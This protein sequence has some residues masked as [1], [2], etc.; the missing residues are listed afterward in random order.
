MTARITLY[1]LP[2]SPNNLKV[3]LALGYKGLAYDREPLQ[4]EQFPGD[5]STLVAVSGQP[6][7]PVLKHGETVIFDSGAIVRYLE[8]NFR[9]TP[10]LFSADW[11]VHGEIEQWELFARTAI[12]SVVGGVFQQA[13]APPPD[14][15]A[16]KQARDDLQEATGR[17]EDQLAKGAFLV[18]DSPTMADIACVPLVALGTLP[19]ALRCLQPALPVALRSS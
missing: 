8:A 17:I 9:D 6:R 4:F 2:P 14:P 10:P 12:G 13:L 7:T 19:P 15:Q 11:H 1:E 18:G 3:R 16:L 5:R